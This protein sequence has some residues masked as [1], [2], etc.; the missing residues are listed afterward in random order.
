MAMRGGR[1][2]GHGGSAKLLRVRYQI[3]CIE[4]NSFA[5]YH[6]KIRFAI[7]PFLAYL[8]EFSQGP[9]G[10]SK[11]VR[12]QRRRTVSAPL[13]RIAVGRPLAGSTSGVT[14]SAERCIA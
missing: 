8:V 13:T 12:D 5:E 6:G 9:K 2:L 3:R 4:A 1:V 7:G 14:T 10:R 11:D